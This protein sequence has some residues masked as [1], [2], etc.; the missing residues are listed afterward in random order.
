MQLT[1]LLYCTI[2]RP[3]DEPKD[4]IVEI[5]NEAIFSILCI[6]VTICDKKSMWFSGLDKILLYTL[7]ING[8]LISIVVTVDLIIKIRK[9]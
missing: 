3:F 1:A 6:I 8:F 4:N 5:L 9:A 7:M 2:F